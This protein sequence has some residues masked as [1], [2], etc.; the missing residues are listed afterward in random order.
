MSS[1]LNVNASSTVRS[2]SRT[3][4][5]DAGL[6]QATR[7][8]S[9]AQE[10]FPR[11]SESSTRLEEQYGTE[12]EIDKPRMRHDLRRDTMSPKYTDQEEKAVLRKLDRKLVLFLSF[13]YLLSFLDRSSNDSHPSRCVRSLLIILRH[14]QCSSCRPRSSTRT[15]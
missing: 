13:L 11:R 7:M 3:R 12:P 15:V 14:R 6:S 4:Q 8:S 2:R 10:D 1:Y 9:S 5:E